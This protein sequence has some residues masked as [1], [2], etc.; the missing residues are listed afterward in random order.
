MIHYPGQWNGS[1][2][3]DTTAKKI[4]LE[5]VSSNATDWILVV[6]YQFFGHRIKINFTRATPNAEAVNGVSHPVNPSVRTIALAIP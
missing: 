6:Q 4:K 3:K 5:N 2:E 1:I